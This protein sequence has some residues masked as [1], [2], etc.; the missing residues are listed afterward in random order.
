MEAW[1]GGREVHS[2]HRSRS[3]V[4][5]SAEY[6]IYTITG[7]FAV[8]QL[9]LTRFEV[10]LS[11]VMWQIPRDLHGQASMVRAAEANRGP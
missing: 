10:L 3:G 4:G 5:H 11:F 1:D 8:R 2:N 6:L 9:V 7:V